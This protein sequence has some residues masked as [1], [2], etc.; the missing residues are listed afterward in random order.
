MLLVGMK[1]VGIILITLVYQGNVIFSSLTESFTILIKR[2]SPSVT[3][4]VEAEGAGVQA[5]EAQGGGVPRGAGAG[6]VE[7]HPGVDLTEVGGAVVRDLGVTPAEA[8]GC[9]HQSAE[10]EAGHDDLSAH[11]N[12][13][14]QGVV[15]LN[16]S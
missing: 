9:P 11:C 5:V 16:C 6:G 15:T 3:E 8:R 7:D 14:S 13:V 10:D 1:K 12:G 4:T 2:L